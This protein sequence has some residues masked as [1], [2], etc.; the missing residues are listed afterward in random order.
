MSKLEL[1]EDEQTLPL[2]YKHVFIIS[3]F[4]HKENHVQCLNNFNPNEQS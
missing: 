2:C 4:L 3:L 1:R